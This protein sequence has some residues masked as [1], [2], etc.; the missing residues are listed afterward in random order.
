MDHEMNGPNT[1]APREENGKT[2]DAPVNFFEQL[3]Q[4]FQRNMYSF[5][6]LGF[7]LL[8]LQDSEGSED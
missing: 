4:F 7:A 5:L 2:N 1:N 3:G 8:L 6:I